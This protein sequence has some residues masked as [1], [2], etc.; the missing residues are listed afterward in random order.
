V[1]RSNTGLVL[2]LL[3]F[4]IAINYLD[5]GALSVSAPLIAK[6]LNLSPSQLGLLFSAFFWS[7][8]GFQLVAGWMVDRFPVKTVYAGGY[9]LWSLATAAVAV[10]GSLPSLVFARLLLGIGESVAYPAC[11]RIL[12]REFPEERRGFANAWIDAGSKIGPGLSTLLGGLAVAQ[13][14]W[15]ALFLVVGLGSLLWLIPWMLSTGGGSE[16]TAVEDGAG[17]GWIDL[18]GCREV[19]GTSL[20]MFALG[21]VWYF[22][23]SWLPSYLVTERGFSMSAMAVAGSVPFWGMAGASLLAGWASDRSIASGGDPTRVRKS[24][25]AGGLLLCAAALLPV[26]FVHSAAVSLAMTTAA[27]LALG[28][29]TS[30]VWAIT[31]TLAGPR[32]AG[33]WTGLQNGIGN[34]GGV[35]S[36][37]VTGWIVART[38]SFALA[39]VTAAAVLL[40]GA[41]AY[42]GMVRRVRPVFPES[43]P[44]RI[45]M[46]A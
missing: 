28:L 43:A 39:F 14:G 27:C 16:Q 41:C 32:A 42:L 30:N 2:T 15:R 6:D 40:A 31:Q 7:Y 34:L 12:A 9:A 46:G 45:T 33:K 10:A 22:L 4:S 11:S 19:W 23:L 21:Y 3:V 8:A 38:G 36:P 26:A 35:V 37:L 44:A 13:F 29:F 18:L 5:R 25:V 17:P 1:T 24:Y 20:G